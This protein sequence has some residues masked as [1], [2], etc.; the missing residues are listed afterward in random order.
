MRTRDF[1]QTDLSPGFMQS[2]F[3]TKLIL[4]QCLRIPFQEL[5]NIESIIL[6]LTSRPTHDDIPW[7]EIVMRNGC[8]SIFC[9][10]SNTI[11]STA[12]LWKCDNPNKIIAAIWSFVW[13]TYGVVSTPSI[14]LAS[15]YKVSSLLPENTTSLLIGHNHNNHECPSHMD[16][17]TRAFP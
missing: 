14:P 2:W 17:M 10:N 13:S 11:P 4:C 9:H 6:W 7:I 1:K 15:W 3:K 16:E 5:G 8:G 12:T